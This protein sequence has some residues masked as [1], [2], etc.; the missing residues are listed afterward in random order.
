MASIELKLK[1]IGGTF[2]STYTKKT[3]ELLGNPEVSAEVD[4]G[5]PSEDVLRI[6]QSLGYSIKT[7]KL[8]DGMVT[9]RGGK[10]KS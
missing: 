10:E 4:E 8:P 1:G 9:L 7:S 5:K 6:L 3:L 2:P